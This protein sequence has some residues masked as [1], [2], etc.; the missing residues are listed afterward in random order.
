MSLSPDAAGGVHHP[1]DLLITGADEV[2]IRQELTLV[3][4]GKKP[5][6]RALRVGRL[7]DVHT[8]TWL[9]DQQNTARESSIIVGI[10]PL[11]DGETA[12]GSDT[13][14]PIVLVGL[15]LLGA[16]LVAAV[17]TRLVLSAF[18]FA[19]QPA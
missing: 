19:E 2:A 17:T 14:L 4:L 15:H 10:W 5:A 11:Q 9:E 13:S 3:A 7:L 6:D 18:A 8:R 12:F 16:A 1:D